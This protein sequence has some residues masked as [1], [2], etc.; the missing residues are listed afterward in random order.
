MQGRRDPSF[1]LTKKTP[2]RRERRRGLW[3]RRQELQTNNLR[4][5]YVREPTES[6]VYPGGEW[7]P[8]GDQYYNHTTSVEEERWPWTD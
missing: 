6:I 4:E 7:F 2:L 5:L 3:Y 1:F 8:E